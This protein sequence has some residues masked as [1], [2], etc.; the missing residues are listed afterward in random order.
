MTEASQTGAD[1][2]EQIDNALSEREAIIAELQEGYGQREN[3]RMDVAE[4]IERLA[5]ELQAARQAGDKNLELI[6]RKYEVE[7]QIAE[8]EQRAEM[9]TYTD[10]LGRIAA[11]L[12]FEAGEQDPA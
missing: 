12:A 2:P 1:R 9:Q 5:G 8:A 3:R 10:S 6:A 11:F 4:I 7:R